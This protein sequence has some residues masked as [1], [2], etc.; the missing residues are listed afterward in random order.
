MSYTQKATF[1]WATGA[2]TSA[3]VRASTFTLRGLATRAN[4]K[5]TNTM[6]KE[7]KSGP[8]ALSTLGSIR[9][10]IAMVQANSSGVMEVSSRAHLS[11]ARWKAMGFISGATGAV[12]KA[13]GRTT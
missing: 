13:Y 6:A 12:I 9:R 7:R 10:A 1:M 8:I 11:T 4:G 5:M 2:M 3:V